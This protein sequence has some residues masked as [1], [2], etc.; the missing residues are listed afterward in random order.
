MNVSSYYKDSAFEK[1]GH[2]KI[3]GKEKP[4]G[5]AVTIFITIIALLFVALGAVVVIPEDEFNRMGKKN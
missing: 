1:T 2:L 4:D 3:E 5:F